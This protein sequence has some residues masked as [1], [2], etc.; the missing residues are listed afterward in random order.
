M[1][2]A[3]DTTLPPQREVESVGEEDRRA[4]T[5]RDC[6]EKGSPCFLAQFLPGAPGERS[7]AGLGLG[8]WRAKA[9]PDD[10]AGG[11]LNTFSALLPASR[12]QHQWRTM[13]RP[14]LTETRWLAVCVGSR[15]GVLR[16]EWVRRHLHRAGVGGRGDA[17]VSG[18][19]HSLLRFW[20][21]LSSLRQPFSWILAP[22]WD[23]W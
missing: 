18:L 1:P 14:G 15:V 17:C 9:A 4:R 7:G 6:C 5:S 2:G 12:L 21:P 19:S 20:K 23:S 13:A 3:V 10:Q 16:W 22:V 8:C 11:D